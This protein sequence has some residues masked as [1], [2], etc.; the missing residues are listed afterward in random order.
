MAGGS[1]NDDDG[2]EEEE[3]EDEDEDEGARKDGYKED[4]Y[5]VGQ[6]GRFHIAHIQWKR[7]WLFRFTS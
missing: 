1:E 3:D 5:I 7:C 2:E 4:D 6:R